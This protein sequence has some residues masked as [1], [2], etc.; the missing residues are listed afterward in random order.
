MTPRYTPH[1]AIRRVF[2][3]CVKHYGLSA[4]E[5]VVAWDSAMRSPA[6]AYRCYLAISRSLP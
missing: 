1:A 4:E 3:R 2:L 5:I 6:N